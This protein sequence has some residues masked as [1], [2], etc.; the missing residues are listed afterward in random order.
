MCLFKG[1]IVDVVVYD[2]LEDGGL[3]EVYKVFGG[4][5]GG[6]MVDCEFERYI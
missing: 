3:L 1:G 4:D 2:V 6:M 5:W